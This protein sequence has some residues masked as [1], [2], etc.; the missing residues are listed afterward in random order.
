MAILYCNPRFTSRRRQRQMLLAD[1]REACQDGL[2][3]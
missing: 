3:P 2:D 1:G